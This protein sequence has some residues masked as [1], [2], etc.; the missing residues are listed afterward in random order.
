MLKHLV[1]ARHCIICL[2][3]KMLSLSLRY[4]VG[5]RDIHRIIPMKCVKY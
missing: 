1:S 3:T 4:V 5:H 2:G